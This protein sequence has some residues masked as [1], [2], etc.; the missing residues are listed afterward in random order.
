MRT[1]LLLLV[2]PLF[3]NGQNLSRAI[4]IDS[5]VTAIESDPAITRVVHDSTSYLKDDETGLFDTAFFHREIFFKNRQVVK[6]SAWNKFKTWRTDLLLFYQNEKLIRFSMGETFKGE[7]G[8]GN[9]HYQVYYNKDNGFHT[10]WLTPKPDNVLNIATESCLKMAYTY[11]K[12]A[13]R[14]FP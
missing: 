6:I 13:R 11:L 5:I 7:P 3:T 10:A 9:L 8:Y 12:D 2:F 4:K 1:I 14:W